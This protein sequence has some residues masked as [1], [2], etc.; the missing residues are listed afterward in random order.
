MNAGNGLDAPAVLG[1]ARA[2]AL[3]LA[4][5]GPVALVHGDLHSANVLSGPGAR[6][7]AIDP[8]PAWA[9]RTSTPWTGCSTGSR[10]QPCRSGGSRGWWRWF[11]VC[12]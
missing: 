1:R 10:I 5:S 4:E 7:V 3:E 8:R 12:P 2:R 6:M 11:P 9:T